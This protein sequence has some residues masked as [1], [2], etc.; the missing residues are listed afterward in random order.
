[1]P[2]IKGTVPD[3]DAHLRVNGETGTDEHGDQGVNPWAK[4]AEEVGPFDEHME[5]D[6]KK[7]N[8]EVFDSEMNK[9]GDIKFD[10][11]EEAENNGE[12]SYQEAQEVFERLAVLEDPENY[13][14]GEIKVVDGRNGK[15]VEELFE[16]YG[17][18]YSREFLEERKH[19]ITAH[20]EQFREFIDSFDG[21]LKHARVCPAPEFS[22][23]A[24]INTKR[25][26]G[27]IKLDPVFVDEIKYMKEKGV[28][29]INLVASFADKDESGEITMAL[30]DIEEYVS[31]IDKLVGQVGAEG[32]I[33]SIGNETNDSMS[34]NPDNLEGMSNVVI[35]EKIPPEEYGAFYKEVTSRLKGKYPEL[36]FCPA[37]T[38]FC[39]P[40][41]T[42]EVL[43]AIGD[44]SLIDVVDFHPYRNEVDV[45]WTS[46]GE[47]VPGWSYDDY[48]N[49]LLR[50]AESHGAR[51]IVGEV[52]FGG[53]D[54]N[55]EI[56]QKS[57]QNL[58]EALA[59]SAAKGIKS[60]VWPRL[61]LPF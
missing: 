11:L 50:I 2:D 31:M 39:A 16:E 8:I 51:L 12:I 34:S 48:E 55:P 15:S 38:A 10:E 43:A 26:N 9:I 49:E 27:D 52:Q 20:E 40:K 57:R 36:Q 18:E 54:E 45:A 6:I 19:Q 1:M 24:L 13:G 37:G 30:P 33:I 5:K 61:G 44:D 53:G 56:I 46:N 60:N 35:S 7:D 17:G 21:K 23:F 58:R 22:P 4:M 29:E 28:S 3:S 25:K 42:S 59:R 47:E 32:L 41:Y 14:V